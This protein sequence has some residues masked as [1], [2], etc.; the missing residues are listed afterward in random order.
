MANRWLQR[1]CYTASLILHRNAPVG[2]AARPDNARVTVS[3]YDRASD[4]RRQAEN[5]PRR[6]A[7]AQAPAHL[8]PQP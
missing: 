1:C 3:R 4:R 7:A 6:G 8:A 2:S 5:R